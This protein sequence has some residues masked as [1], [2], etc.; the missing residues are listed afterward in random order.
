MV[1]VVY[2]RAVSKGVMS[3]GTFSAAAAAASSS[4]SR[5]LAALDF[6][7]P[8]F[9]SFPTRCPSVLEATVSECVC[10]CARVGLGG[11]GWVGWVGV[12]GEPTRR[13]LKI[14]VVVRTLLFAFA[15]ALAS[16]SLSSFA[17]FLARR[18]GCYSLRPSILPG[19]G[20]PGSRL[21]RPWC[22]NLLIKLMKVRCEIS[23]LNRTLMEENGVEQISL[24]QVEVNCI[25]FKHFF[26]MFLCSIVLK[27]CTLLL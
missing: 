27:P 24:L 8:S 13:L 4:F 15:L 5:R 26:E 20:R 18:A 2:K 21:S 12:L 1:R 10:M 22:N 14:N 3:V 23:S 6:S 9:P 16:L 7:G 11:L 19:P 17:P 25:F